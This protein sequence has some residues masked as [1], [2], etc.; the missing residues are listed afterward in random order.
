MPTFSSRAAAA[1]LLLSGSHIHHSDA[2]VP[3][4]VT[5][6]RDLSTVVPGTHTTALSMVA[7]R[8]YSIFDEQ[9]TNNTDG[10]SLKKPKYQA[11]PPPNFYKILGLDGWTNDL[12]AVKHAYRQKAKEC[13]PDAVSDNDKATA[14]VVFQEITKAYR[15]LSNPQSKSKYDLFGQHGPAQGGGFVT[16][17][18][19][20]MVMG[21]DESQRQEKNYSAIEVEKERL[22]GGH[23]VNGRDIRI[24]MEIDIK[25]GTYGGQQ[26]IQMS[27]LDRCGACF[28]T[29]RYPVDGTCC[30]T[31]GGRG[32]L[33]RTKQVLVRVPPGSSRG[34]KIHRPG[35]GDV[36]LNG[37]TNGDL[38]IVLKSK[39]HNSDN[40]LTF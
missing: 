19:G 14:A 8:M 9:E 1:P 25:T 2:F 29:G 4:Q 24:D 16:F 23:P 3:A 11:P 34:H 21:T 6:S 26:T 30:G 35:L 31:C 36:G 28:G 20:I 37:G 10:E 13:H 12:S 17:G 22:E 33:A 38:V 32:R 40:H 5:R 18:G 7:S 39:G 27:H 15:V